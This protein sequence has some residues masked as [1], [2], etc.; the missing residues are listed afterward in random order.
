MP[1]RDTTSGFSILLKGSKYHTNCKLCNAVIRIGEPCYWRRTGDGGVAC[2]KCVTG[3]NPPERKNPE[4][5]QGEWRKLVGFLRDSVLVGSTA[6]L[7][8][9]EEIGTRHQW[10]G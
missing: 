8:S 9:P 5:P 6:D 2:V 1:A 10:R 3:K 4:G 7:M